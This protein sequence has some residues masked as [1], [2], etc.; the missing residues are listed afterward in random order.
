VVNQRLV[1]LGN[2]VLLVDIIIG[3]VDVQPPKHIVSDDRGFV[4]RFV[5][6][7]HLKKKKRAKLFGIPEQLSP[8]WL[9][10]QPAY[11][12]DKM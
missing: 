8:V 9:F 4:V 6:I 5:Q 2:Q 12:E 1:H 10:P 7:F 11:C 3:G